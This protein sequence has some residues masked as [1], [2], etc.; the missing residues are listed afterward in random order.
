MAKKSARCWKGQT[1]E[2][3]SR[4]DRRLRA[5]E[6]ALSQVN[7]DWRAALEKRIA[8]IPLQHRLGHLRAVAGLASPRQEIKAFCLMCV[9][10]ERLE[11]AQCTNVLC[12]HYL[13][14]PYQSHLN[15]PSGATPLAEG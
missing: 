5:S 6:E 12:P 11:V 3:L 7:P 8:Q 2:A 14:R 15:G 10:W 13:S 1:Q 9:G 4:A